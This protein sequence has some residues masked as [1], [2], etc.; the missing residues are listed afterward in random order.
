M[1]TCLRTGTARRAVGK[2]IL[3]FMLPGTTWFY[4]AR[5]INE[6]GFR[7]ARQVKLSLQSQSSTRNEE[8]L[9]ETG[10]E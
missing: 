7:Y 1:A 2:A 8:P 5:K 10:A 3:S 9:N 6:Y 4:H